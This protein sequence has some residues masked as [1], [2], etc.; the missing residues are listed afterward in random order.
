MNWY[1]QWRITNAQSLSGVS[2]HF[3]CARL[4]GLGFTNPTQSANAEFQ[5][6]VNLT[7]R[8]AERIMS[9]L[10]E[11]GDEAEITQLQEEAKKE[12]EE[13][14]LKR[15]DEW[16]NSLPARTKRA[17][18][19]AWEKGASTWLTVIPN[20]DTNCDLN[21]REL[22]DAIH[23]RYGW[24]IMGTL[25]VC[26]CGDRF[27]VDRTMLCKHGGFII[28]RHNELRDLEADLLD[29][30][31]NNVETTSSTRNYRRD[32]KQR[33]K[34]GLWR[35]PRHPCT[36]IL[37]ETKVDLFW[38]NSMPSKPWLIWRSY[39]RTSVSTSWKREEKTVWTTSL[40][41]GTSVLY[42]TSIHRNRRFGTWMLNP[43]SSKPGDLVT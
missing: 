13:R 4:G 42:A 12:K 9:Q 17:V 7:A 10:Y 25:T 1:L 19:L 35:P 30:V 20:K 26:V 37:G 39:A 21:K 18:S 8:L 11:P 34:V 3:Q 40:G 27:S 2:Y 38:Y 33:C 28:Q 43:F 16:R 41:S 14:L 29:L 23:L 36:W 15:S 32:L 6:S 22:K 31:C 24:E 5:A